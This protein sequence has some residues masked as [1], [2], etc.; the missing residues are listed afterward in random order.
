[1]VLPCGMFTSGHAASLR[2]QHG[3]VGCFKTCVLSTS[4]D[5]K[6]ICLLQ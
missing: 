6:H 5:S 1:M 4:F 2:F 3:K